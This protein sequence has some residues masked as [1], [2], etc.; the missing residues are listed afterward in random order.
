MLEI[1]QNDIDSFFFKIS[2]FKSLLCGSILMLSIKIKNMHFMKILEKQLSIRT[3]AKNKKKNVLLELS[4]H[5]LLF[6]LF[7]YIKLCEK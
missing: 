4:L 5:H 2:K 6:F 3:R 1:S 7:N